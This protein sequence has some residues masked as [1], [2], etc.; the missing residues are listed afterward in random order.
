MTIAESVKLNTSSVVTAANKAAGAVDKLTASLRAVG[1]I[2]LGDGVAEKL[3]GITRAVEGEKAAAAIKIAEGKAAA[4]SQVADQ[5][6][7]HAQR[8]AD[9]KGAI[10]SDL[11]G[12]KATAAAKAAEDKTANAAALA[13]QKGTIA[14]QLAS[15]K[16]SSASQL[17]Q[18]KAVQQALLA[19]QKNMHAIVLADSKSEQTAEKQ[20][21][22]VLKQETKEREKAAN[23]SKKAASSPGTHAPAAGGGAGAAGANSAGGAI[24]EFL[25]MAET[26]A[27]IAA[28]EQ[29]YGAIFGMI[30]K[31]VQ[32]SMSL[33]LAAQ[34]FKDDALD[35]FQVLLGG[36]VAAG[37][38]YDSVIKLSHKLGLSR[39]KAMVETKRLLSAG[40]SMKEIPKML[41]A[42]ADLDMTREGGGAKLEKIM[43]GIKGKGHLDK[44][45]IAQ[46]GK[47]GVGEDAVYAELAKQQHKTVDQVKALV[48]TNQIDSKSGIDAV[49][50]SVE[51][52]F[53][54]RAKADAEDVMTLIMVIKDQLFELFDSVNIG[55]LQEVLKN[56]R[57]VLEDGLGQDMKTAITE[58]MG[59]LFEA[60]FGPLKDKS[61]M[62][63]IVKGITSVIR[64]ITE[65]IKSITP[66]I[67]TFVDQFKA[68][69]AKMAPVV[70]VVWTGVSKLFNTIGGAAGMAGIIGRALGIVVGV[71]VALAG[72]VTFVM[73]IIGAFAGVMLTAIAGIIDIFAEFWGASVAFIAGIIDTLDQAFN[74]FADAYNQAVAAGGSI[75]DG[76]AAGIAGGAG[77][78]IDAIINVA[79]SAIKAAKSVLDTNSPS[80]VFEEIGGWTA[81]GMEQ[82]IDGGA[83]GV[84]GAVTRMGKAATAAAVAVPSA[85][86]AGTAL[87]A[88]ADGAKA[89]GGGDTY[90]IT[91]HAND[92]KGGE[93]A[94]EGFN[95]RM[96][97]FNRRKAAQG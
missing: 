62:E 10:A 86:G 51:G 97:E 46:L 29:V 15:Q 81:E 3:A 95:R 78:V 72:A 39:E 30:S 59:S 65:F 56:V 37:A 33:T 35:S 4:Q 25:G 96:A 11:A 18:Q 77:A 8:L 20:K 94:A 49:L 57:D 93:A 32:G 43:E 45:A 42:I 88:G 48:K 64:G 66:T 50:N 14:A 70:G 23:A 79:S 63:S 34:S 13:A 28:V 76:L 85:V 9:I 74:K 19:G 75:V 87:S 41:E 89:G 60:V 71:L 12:Q 54:G 27:W 22:E 26:G 36:E 92:A 16:A 47:L 80:K 44:G 21:L 53:G 17:A 84:V 83:K 7:A 5:K 82:G 40:Y 6:A 91:I 38:A 67:H 58:M 1:G 90:N 61:A 31:L 2:S 68:G 73:G 24:T 55:P 69:F 52:K